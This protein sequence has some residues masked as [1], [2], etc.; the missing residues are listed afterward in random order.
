MTISPF[1][2]SDDQSMRRRATVLFRTR[3]LRFSVGGVVLS[4][5]GPS[6]GVGRVEGSGRGLT[7]P[8][9]QIPRHG[10][11]GTTPR[12][13]KKRRGPAGTEETSHGSRAHIPRRPSVLLGMTGEPWR[14]QRHSSGRPLARPACG[15]LGQGSAPRRHDKARRARAARAPVRWLER[16][17]GVPGPTS[18][19]SGAR[20]GCPGSSRAS[21]LPGGP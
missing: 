15:R 19:T 12:N 8:P 14:L 16:R 6:C 11:C 17:E 9:P 10:A 1:Q 13:D 5:R 7:F 4:S 20:E 3:G 21:P 2:R 18:P